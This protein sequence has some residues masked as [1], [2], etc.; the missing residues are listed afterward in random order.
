[1]GWIGKLIGGTL[2]FALGGPLGAIAGAA[3]GHTIDKSEELGRMESPFDGG[4]SGGADPFTRNRGFGFPYGRS[5]NP[6]QQ[7]QI[8]FFVG[9]F[10]MIAKVALADG[11]VSRDEVRKV[12]EF[13]DRDL[14]LDPDSRNTASR[15]FHT[16]VRSGERFDDLAYQFYGQFR[17]QPQILELLI[18]ILYRV[19]AVD[20]NVVEEEQ[21]LIDRAASIFHFSEARMETI[22]NR[23]V[24][25]LEKYYAVLGLGSKASNDE[26]KRAYRRLVS[27]YHPDKIASKGLPE[28][29]NTFAHEKFREIQGA[30]EK[31]RQERGI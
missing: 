17:N 25:D 24:S 9:A 26:I 6:R 3:F 19:A 4:T 23:Y 18:D 14:N 29:F 13:M 31:I 20:N 15:I 30:Y 10:S 16:A 12:E 8:T 28:E 2:G 27:E 22:R 1:M 7:A 21:R 11:E 5:M